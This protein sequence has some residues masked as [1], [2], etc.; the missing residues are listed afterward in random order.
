MDFP[1][2]GAHVYALQRLER[3]EAFH[4]AS[5]FY[6]RLH[7]C[8]FLFPGCHRDVETPGTNILAATSPTRITPST[9]W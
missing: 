1:G 7:R 4:D 9:I 2:V 5:D 3:A 8:G 6:D